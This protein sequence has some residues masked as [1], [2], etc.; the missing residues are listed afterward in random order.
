M[1]RPRM[2]DWVSEFQISQTTREI[3]AEFGKKVREEPH[4]YR[5]SYLLYFIS[6]RTLSQTYSPL[7]YG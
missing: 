3:W 5:P 2:F 7:T 1:G 6:K 4:I